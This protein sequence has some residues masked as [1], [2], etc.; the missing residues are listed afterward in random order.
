ME[1]LIANSVLKFCTLPLELSVEDSA[2]FRDFLSV[3]FDIFSVVLLLSYNCVFNINSGQNLL[4]L[5]FLKHY[6]LYRR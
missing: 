3:K 6:H 2:E 1:S 5:L 4:R